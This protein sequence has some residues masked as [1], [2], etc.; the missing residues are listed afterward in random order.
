MRKY[1]HTDIHSPSLQMSTFS[2]GT[3]SWTVL[4]PYVSSFQVH[5]CSHWYEHA[6]QK[7]ENREFIDHY[8]YLMSRLARMTVCCVLVLLHVLKLFHK[9]A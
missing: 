6:W 7:K 1:S 3:V 9:F 4:G 8:K 2:P 5:S